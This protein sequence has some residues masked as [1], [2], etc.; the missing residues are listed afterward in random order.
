MIKVSRCPAAMVHRTDRIGHLRHEAEGDAPASNPG[1]RRSPLPACRRRRDP[2]VCRPR[3]PARH[4]GRV[5]DRRLVEIAATE[6]CYRP[7]DPDNTGGSPAGQKPS[8]GS[9]IEEL[10]N[11][12]PSK[13]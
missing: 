1:V 13:D 10:G 8:A 11:N 9:N 7:H 4:E 5:G 3:P 2:V 12:T 6:G